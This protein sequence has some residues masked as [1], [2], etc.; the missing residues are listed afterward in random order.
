MPFIYIAQNAYTT[1]GTRD[2]GISWSVDDEVES[3]SVDDDVE[4]DEDSVNN[5]NS[6]SITTATIGISQVVR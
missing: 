3:W 2:N 1:H 6:N 4:Y 5:S